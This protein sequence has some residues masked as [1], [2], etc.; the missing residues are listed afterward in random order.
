MPNHNIYAGESGYLNAVDVVIPTYARG[1]RA[2][3]VGE[4]LRPQLKGKDRIFIVWQGN[5]PAPPSPDPAI[6]VIHSPR[7]NL[8]RARNRGC[9]AGKGAVVIFLDDDV[10]VMDNLIANH[11]ISY[12]DQATG[13]VA[14]RVDDPLFDSSQT[15]PS[16][17]EPQTGAL[18]QNFNLDA[19]QETISF[20]GANMSVAR[21][22][23]SQIGGFDERFSGNGLWE[24]IDVAFRLRAAGYTIRYCSGAG[25]RHL[26]AATGGCRSHR[27]YRYLY[28]QFANTAYFAFKHAD[29]CYRVSWI[30][31]WWYRLEYLSRT[32]R[33]FP[34]HDPLAVAAAMMGAVCG[35]SR[36]YRNKNR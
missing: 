36:G 26:R 29:R 24:E 11:R 9:A 23:L 21:S 14:G 12:L 19:D 3:N 8:P 28:H 30:R 33:R 22:A 15:V 18:R 16:V 2:L 13:G 10:E 27:A 1:D 4:K 5:D 34:R 6:S 7:P 20:M 17:F 31:F 32:G 25:V 35:I